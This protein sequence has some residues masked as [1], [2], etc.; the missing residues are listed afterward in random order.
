MGEELVP[1][2]C[3]QYLGFVDPLVSPSCI[4]GTGH[5]A[6]DKVVLDTEQDRLQLHHPHRCVDDRFE[7]RLDRNTAEEL[8]YNNHC[9][10]K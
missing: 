8:S 1:N 7:Q 3:N 2:L 4:V 10:S 9:Q 5:M 6:A